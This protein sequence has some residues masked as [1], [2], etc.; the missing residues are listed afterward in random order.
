MSETL[1]LGVTGMTCGGCENAVRRALARVN[2]VQEVT[3]SH[4]SNM[5]AVTFDASAVTPTVIRQTIEA[6]G[7]QVAA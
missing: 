4:A 2:G 7:Y 1:Q 3:A 6:L 5:V